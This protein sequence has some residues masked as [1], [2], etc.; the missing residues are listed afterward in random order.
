MEALARQEKLESDKRRKPDINNRLVASTQYNSSTVKTASGSAKQAAQP[1]SVIQTPSMISIVK[2]QMHPY[3]SP[4]KQQVV[5]VKTVASL[6]SEQQQPGKTT[7]KTV[8]SLLAE[9]RL[10]PR[11]TA[12]ASNQAHVASQ[13]MRAA[14]PVQPHVQNVVTS[15]NVL[16]VLDRL[17]SAT[18][19]MNV[20]LQSLRMDARKNA[21]GN[22]PAHYQKRREIAGKLTRAYAAYTRSFQEVNANAA[23]S[24]NS[25]AA[26]H[27]AR[28]NAIKAQQGSVVMRAPPAANSAAA[29][30]VSRPT[31]NHPT[32]PGQMPPKKST[33]SEVIEISDSED[34]RGSSSIVKTKTVKQL[35]SQTNVAGNT[36][37]IHASSAV[38]VKVTSQNRTSIKR[39]A[40][41]P[42][43]AEGHSPTSNVPAKRAHLDDSGEAAAAEKPQ[44]MSSS[45]EDGVMFDGGVEEIPPDDVQSSDDHH[46]QMYCIEV[47]DSDDSDTP[48][49]DINLEN[50][51]VQS[52]Q[53][54]ATGRRPV[55]SRSFLEAE[56]TRNINASRSVVSLNL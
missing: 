29:S 49:S 6:L 36:P 32:M 46:L 37:E 39:R 23:S 55:K 43:A 52:V 24:S 31:N 19:S 21:V 48:L 50:G 47:N 20:F 22:T 4:A 8:A 44:V 38:R 7:N 11:M 5:K 51:K 9:Q 10:K 15:Q 13:A 26:S 1:V 28:V 18:N 35:T 42:D 45:A 41:L 25:T 53:A 16:M 14:H 34:E 12:P 56:L 30:S 3:T 33:S 2:S 40:Q 17:Q 27:A 54:T